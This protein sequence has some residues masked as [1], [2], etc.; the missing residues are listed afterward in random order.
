[1]LRI[2]N[3]ARSSPLG[4]MLTCSTYFSLTESEVVPGYGAVAVSPL[5]PG[6]TTG[7]E[8]LHLEANG[9]LQLDRKSMKPPC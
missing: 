2:D 8:P 5:A 4:D 1:M 9:S 7:E 6:L 3:T